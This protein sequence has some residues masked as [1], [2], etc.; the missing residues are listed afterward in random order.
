ME[1]PAVGNRPLGMNDD[2]YRIA[3]TFVITEYR[4]N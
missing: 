2:A 3:L 1:T 4:N